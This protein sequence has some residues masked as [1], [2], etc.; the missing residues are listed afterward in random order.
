[1]I[2]EIR[3][4]ESCNESSDFH[5]S[6]EGVILCWACGLPMLKAVD[7]LS[8]EVLTEI[9]ERPILSIMETSVKCEPIINPIMPSV[10]EFKKSIGNIEQKISELEKVR[11]KSV[12]AKEKLLSSEKFS[13]GDIEDLYSQQKAA[14]SELSELSKKLVVAKRALSW[15]M[16]DRQNYALAQVELVKHESKEAEALRAAGNILSGIRKLNEDIALLIGDTKQFMPIQQKR[17]YETQALLR[18]L[19]TLDVNHIKTENAE[20]DWIT[21][22]NDASPAMR[23]MREHL[24][25]ELGRLANSFLIVESC[26]W[27]TK[28]SLQWQDYQDTQKPDELPSY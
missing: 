22:K 6:P 24:F 23:I 27:D 26:M 10:A 19:K 3:I 14:E 15:A 1:M 12:S 11:D 25:K 7:V 18:T 28:H 5:I 20:Y 21:L 2:S 4:C 9:L 13:Y 16:Q 8:K 17:Y